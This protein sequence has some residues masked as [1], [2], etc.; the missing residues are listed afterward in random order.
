MPGLGKLFDYFHFKVQFFATTDRGQVELPKL[1]GEAQ[2]R[3]ALVEVDYKFQSQRTPEIRETDVRRHR[4]QL[5]GCIKRKGR[6]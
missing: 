3:E 6:A 2:R 4:F 5:R 1:P